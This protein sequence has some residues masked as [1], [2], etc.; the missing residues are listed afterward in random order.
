MLDFI[1]KIYDEAYTESHLSGLQAVWDAA[2]S[3]TKAAVVVIEQ[4]AEEVIQSVET[5]VEDVAEAVG[6]VDA[7]EPDTEAPA[8]TAEAA[9]PE[10]T[11]TAHD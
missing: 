7:P 10:S 2:V 6:I 5:A 9:A 4:V 11:D 3:H 1:K 8:D